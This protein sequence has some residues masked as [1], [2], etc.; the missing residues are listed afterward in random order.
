MATILTGKGRG[1]SLVILGPFKHAILGPRHNLNLLYQ[2]FVLT[3]YMG[4]VKLSL[5]ISTVRYKLQ[6]S[7]ASQIYQTH[8]TT[9]F[10]MHHILLDIGAQRILEFS[11]KL[12]THYN[13]ITFLTPNMQAILLA[14][15]PHSY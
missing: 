3:L 8:L 7:S 12:F 5:Y 11:T 1:Q 6:V 13:A 10:P 4:F 15:Q 9:V 14:S 2:N